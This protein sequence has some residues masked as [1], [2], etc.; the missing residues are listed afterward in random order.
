MVPASTEKHTRAAPSAAGADDRGRGWLAPVLIM[1]V[2]FA[3]V[4]AFWSWH[5]GVPLRDPE[6]KMF[7]ARLTTSLISFALLVLA[8]AVVRSRRQSFAPRAV[9]G[10]LRAWWPR[11]RLFLAVTGLVAYHVVYVCYRNLKSW[12]AFRTL[13]DRELVDLE[14]WLFHGH[15][16]AALLH[17]V[18]GQG[19]A[20]F[21][22][23]FIYRSFT[24]LVPFSVVASVVFVPKIRDSFVFLTAAMWVWILG[25]GSYYLLPTLGPFAAAAADFSALPHT[26]ITVTQAEYIASRD[27][28]LSTPEAFDS[29]ASLGA[30][31]SLHVAFTCMVVLMLW[32]YRVPWAARIL[33]VVYLLAVMVATVYFGWHYVVD[34][35]AGVI[36]AVLAVTFARL[37]VL[38]RKGATPADA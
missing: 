26:P 21:V 31:A 3:A 37:M 5:V 16:P 7:R 32:H 17:D 1:V 4:T 29:F 20:A 14:L 30:F 19:T 12:N 8:Q 6:G 38:P 27:Q 36:I 2:L 25:V 24:Y 18:F 28:L 13:V 22:L 35:V 34:D 11:E 33:G 9:V 23:A 10:H 15:S